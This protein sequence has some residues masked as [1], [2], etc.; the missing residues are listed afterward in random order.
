M[1]LSIVIVNWKVKDL[2]RNCLDSIFAQ[3]E[4]GNFEVIVVDNNSKDGSEKLVQREFHQVK[5]VRNEENLGFGRACNQGIRMAKGDF[6]LLLNPDT[7]VELDTLRNITNYMKSNARVGIGGC[8]LYNPD[9]KSQTSFYKFT[10]I[11]TLLGRTLFLYSFLPKNSLTAPLFVDY[12]R[13]HE[14]V[15]RVCGGAMVLRY[16]ALE[17]VGLFDDSFFLYYEDEDLCYRMKQ[18][19]WMVAPI[20]NTRIVHHHNQSGKKN[21]AMAIFSSYR[22]QFIFYKKFHPFHKVLIF[23]MVQVV[24]V[25]L[26]S[27]YWLLASITCRNGET[28]KQKFFGYLSVLLSSFSYTRTLIKKTPCE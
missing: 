13:S 10:S 22:S 26:R 1:E 21:V 19:G 14:S 27:L 2:L 23:R 25:S 8:Y 17:Q 28:A 18:K 15:D 7:T 16:E 11:T 12:L 20:P 24:G 6:V 5:L 4:P 3:R 9:G